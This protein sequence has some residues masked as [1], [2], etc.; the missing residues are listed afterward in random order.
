MWLGPEHEGRVGAIQVQPRCDDPAAP[1]KTLPDA[2]V[3]SVTGFGI[4][5]LVDLLVERARPLLPIPGSV[6]INARQAAL[7]EQAQQRLLRDHQDNLLIAEEL[8]MVRT[9]F[10]RLLGNSGVEDML[11]AL[12]GRFCIGK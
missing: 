3:S 7:L 11:D 6:A 4:S 12:F 2:K 1:T 8:R 10:D 9:A 5:E